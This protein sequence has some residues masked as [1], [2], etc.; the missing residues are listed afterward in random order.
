MSHSDNP[1]RPYESTD[2]IREIVRRFEACTFDAGEFRH[3]EHL[4]V[5]LW[6]I[7]KFS[8]SE[9]TARMREGLYKFLDHHKV[10]RRKYHETITRFWVKRVGALYVE[11]KK[12]RPLA[13]I[14]NQVV[15]VCID[16]NLIYAYYSRALLASTTARE[17][18]VEPDV[19]SFDF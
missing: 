7:S 13:E 18:W 14:A 4:A 10:D 2:E 15:K 3:R 1:V 19:Q 5:I 11:D 8:A 17:G 9:A 6:Y 16:A 12:E